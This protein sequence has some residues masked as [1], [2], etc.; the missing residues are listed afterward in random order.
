MNGAGTSPDAVVV[1]AGIVGAACALALSRCGYRVTTVDQGPIAS[2]A[3][4]A[5]M[6]HLCVLDDS[7]EQFALS[8][9]S[10]LLW[11]LLAPELPKS[12]ERSVCGTLWAA[13][14]EDEMGAVYRKEAYY[15]SRGVTAHA[16]TSAEIQ[17]LEPNLRSPSGNPLAGGLLLPEDSIIYAPPAARWMLDQAAANGGRF[18]EGRRVVALE[19][20]VVTLDNGR[21][22]PTGLIVVA[23][24]AWA[25]ELF[26]GIPI[27]PR[28]GHLAITDRMPGFLRHQVVELAYIKNAHGH[29]DESVSFNVQPRPNGQILIGSSRQYTATDASVEP[30][31]L[32]AVLDK[33]CSYMPGLLDV[34]ILRAWCGF[35]A[36][37]PDSLPIIGPHPAIPGL[38][39][40]TG[41]EGL[42]LTT[43]LGTAALLASAVTGEPPPFPAEPYLPSR[44]APRESAP[45]DGDALTHSH[46]H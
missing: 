13:A 8:R 22:M 44:F 20:G 23:T 42:G 14:D 30:R 27:R 26:P 25:P 7:D 10:Q 39:I 32:A 21:K 3:T 41:H 43:S 12:V 6:G 17:Q 28:K 37:S 4:A 46:D 16:L 45:R 15:R 33:A 19:Q 5:G 18:I 2:G 35:R 9:S 24:G 31:M 1:G 36:A 34:K 11:D 29:S 38:F 40:A